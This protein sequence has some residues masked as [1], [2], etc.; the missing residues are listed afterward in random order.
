MVTVLLVFQFISFCL[1][2]I[3]D[4]CHNFNNCGPA[5][6]KS[7]SLEFVSNRQ[8]PFPFPHAVISVCIVGLFRAWMGH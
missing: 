1:L 8:D 4:M 2:Q 7:M 6:E 3:S 5:Y